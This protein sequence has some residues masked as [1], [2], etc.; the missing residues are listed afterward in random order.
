MAEPWSEPARR[1]QRPDRT[2]PTGVNRRRTPAERTTLWWVW[3][4][5]QESERDVKPY[6]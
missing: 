2:N 5:V 1:R 6:L 4:S 3:L